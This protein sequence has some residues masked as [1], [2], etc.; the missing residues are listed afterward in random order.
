MVDASEWNGVF[1]SGASSAVER[2]FGTCSC[3]G[4][5]N[6]VLIGS[7]LCGECYVKR[8]ESSV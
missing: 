8:R 5:Q 7:S 3:C 6:A 1:G 4:K 2:E